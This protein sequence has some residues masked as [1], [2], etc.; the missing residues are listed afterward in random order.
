MSSVTNEETGREEYNG[1]EIGGFSVSF[2]GKCVTSAACNFSYVTW[3]V[4]L[5]PSFAQFWYLNPL[6]GGWAYLIT[7]L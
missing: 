1:R 2:A 5:V 3:V 4:I 6:F 7:P